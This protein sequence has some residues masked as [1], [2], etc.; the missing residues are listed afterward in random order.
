MRQNASQDYF[1]L[2][3]DGRRSAAGYLLTLGVADVSNHSQ[4][5]L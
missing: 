2:L 4:V 3:A 1:Q 5:H